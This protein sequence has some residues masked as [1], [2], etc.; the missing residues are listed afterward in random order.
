M[1]QFSAGG[2]SEWAWGMHN[3]DLIVPGLGD[4]SLDRCS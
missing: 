2:T 1:F 3:G 4:E